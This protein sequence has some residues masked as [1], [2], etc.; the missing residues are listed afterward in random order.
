[1]ERFWKKVD[2]GEPTTCWPWTAG[3]SKF[4]YGRFGFRDANWQAHRVAYTLSKGDVPE[5]LVVMHKCNNRVCCNPAHLDAGTQGDNCQHTK[6]SGRSGRPQLHRILT[7]EEIAIAV[8]A[9]SYR[10]AASML[11][12]GHKKVL[13]IRN[14]FRNGGTQN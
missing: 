2:V 6:A 5:G 13:A 3:K 10:E 4:G 12:V 9:T 14:Q 7:G 1:M 8:K 11:K